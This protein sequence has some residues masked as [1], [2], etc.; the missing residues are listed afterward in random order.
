MV[1]LHEALQCI[2]QIEHAPRYETL[3]IEEAVGRICAQEIHARIDLPV[4]DNS[5]MDGYAIKLADAGKEVRIQE[6]LMAGQ[7]KDLQLEP[8]KAIK[9]MTGAKLPRGCEA[10]VP[11]EYVEDLGDR[12]KLPQ[13]VKLHANMRFAGEDIKSGSMLIE[14][15]EKLCA[16]AIGVLASQGYSYVRTFE[17]VKVAIFSTGNELAMHYEPRS[18]AQIYNSNTPALLARC[19]ELGCATRFLGKIEDDPK[20][21][22][23][24]IANALDAD[25]IITSGGMSVG[26][27]DFTKA[28]FK[29]MGMEILFSKIAIKP[30]KPTTLGKIGSTYVLN[31]PGNPL[32]AILNFEI[33]GRTLIYKLSGRADYHLQPLAAKLKEK[34][35]LK[36]G[37]DTVIPGTFDG[38]FFIPLA[39]YAPGMVRPASLMDG[40]I[41][42][43]KDAKTLEKTVRFIPLWESTSKEA[44]EVVSAV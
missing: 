16:Y 44:Q 37:R 19:K 38:T 17:Q 1:S 12:V 41:I 40:F 14:P 28:A 31:L 5:A 2:T 30:G 34:I 22:E 6:R 27:A 26:E 11:Q 24:A 39:H 7:S 4:F 10:V 13:D 29:S 23:E 33:F 36:P 42:A 21:I 32:A 35:S 3:C 43:S 20:A 25:L 15:G 18:G 8:G 9:I